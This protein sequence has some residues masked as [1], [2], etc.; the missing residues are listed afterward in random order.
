ML[1]RHLAEERSFDMRLQPDGTVFTSKHFLI[2]RNINFTKEIELHFKIVNKWVAAIADRV[3]QTDVK[4]M[5]DAA[6][7]V[8]T[9]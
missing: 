7:V 9:G 4:V 5:A 2:I 3:H 8:A 6:R 1:I